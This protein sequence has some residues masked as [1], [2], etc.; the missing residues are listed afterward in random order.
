MLESLH[1]SSEFLKCLR[2]SQRK[3]RSFDSTS[4][5]TV[6]I[7]LATTEVGVLDLYHAPAVRKLITAT[8]SLRYD[9]PPAD[10]LVGCQ[11]EDTNI[12][13]SYS[14]E[15][16]LYRVEATTSVDDSILSEARIYLQEWTCIDPFAIY[17]NP[18]VLP[19]MTIAKAP[20]SGMAGCQN[21]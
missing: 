12:P 17:Q 8:P 20:G 16:V 14:V 5:P 10:D 4:D 15:I 11:S 6:T 3:R 21:I 1:N 9:A 2:F 18:H 13:I 19:G 7:L